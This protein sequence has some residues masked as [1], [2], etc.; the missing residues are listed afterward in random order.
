MRVSQSV[1]GPG[2][3][4]VIFA[5]AVLHMPGAPVWAVLFFAML[6]TLG[7]ST[8][9]GNMESIITP[10]LDLGFLPTWVPKEALTGECLRWPLPP[11]VWTRHSAGNRGPCHSPRAGLGQPCP[12]SGL[13]LVPCT[14]SMPPRAIAGDWRVS[15]GGSGDPSLAVH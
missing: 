11:A 5:E 15:R 13:V 4:F 1:S 7:L 6:F 3:A 8:M 9:F 2:L 14:D 12:L 10:L